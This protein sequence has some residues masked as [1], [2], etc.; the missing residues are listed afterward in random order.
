MND[1][2]IDLTLLPASARV[3]RRRQPVDRRSRPGRAGGGIR[4]AA[5]RLRRGRAPRPVPRVPRRVRRRV[6]PMR[7]R[8]SCA[9]RWPSSSTRKVSTSTSRPEASCT[10]RCMPASRPARIVMHGNNKSSGELRTALDAGVGRIVVDSFDELDRLED[11]RGSRR[12]AGRGARARDAG[13]RSAHPRVHRD[14]HRRLE[15]RLRPADR[16]RVARGAAGRRARARCASRAC[17]ATSDRRCSASTRSR[18]RSTAWS[19]WCSTVE[20]ETG[21]TVDELSLGGG[22]GVRYVASDEGPSIAQYAAALQEAF[23]KALAAHG[24]RSRPELGVEP[25]PLDRRAGRAH[26]VHRRHGEGD[27]GAAHLRRGRRRDERQ[28]AARHVRRAVRGVPPGARDGATRAGR[29]GRGQALRAGRPARPRRLRSRP[30]CGWATSWRRRSPARTHIRWRRTTTRLPARR[31]SSCATGRRA[32]S[33]VE[34]ISTISFAWTND[35]R[36][37][38]GPGSG[39]DRSARAR[40]RSG[41][42]DR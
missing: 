42:P 34:R 10:S 25:G 28:P 15:V 30:T 6:S 17:T 22:L 41:G 13:C 40:R 9:P 18:R 29:H 38:N 31:W 4:H 1:A 16:R 36:S 26:A 11:A 2:P 35:C 14:R 12:R 33:S 7:A 8:R 39:L 37:R 5:L 20:T 3:C 19:A 21:A 27:P 24:V 23:A 32:W